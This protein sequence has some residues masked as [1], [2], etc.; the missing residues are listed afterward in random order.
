MG[1]YKGFM[2]N[3]RIVFLVLLVIVSQLLIIGS[4]ITN[5]EKTSEMK[6]EKLY[7]RDEVIKVKLNKLYAEWRDYIAQPS[8]KASS[9]S[10]DYIN[11]KPYKEIIGMGSPVIPYIIDKMEKAKLSGNMGIDSILWYAIRDITGVDLTTSKFWSEQEMAEKYINWW[12]QK[13]SESSRG[14]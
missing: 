11:C 13:K 10:K 4:C 6:K 9:L 14:N 2:E 8:V 1:Q 7:E 5:E 12:K 3:N